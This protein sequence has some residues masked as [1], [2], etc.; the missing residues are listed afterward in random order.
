MHLPEGLTERLKR[1][2]FRA[3][4]DEERPRLSE[5]QPLFEAIE[6]QLG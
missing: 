4:L 5:I 6:R 1:E 2:A 3:I